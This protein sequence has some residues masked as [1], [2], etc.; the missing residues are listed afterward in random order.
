MKP[1]RMLIEVALPLDAINSGCEEDKNRKVGHIRNLHKWFA[2]MPL[3]AWRA[4]LLAS[5]I[6][7]PENDV[8]PGLAAKERQ[9]LFRLISAI[10][11]LD[12]IG[13]REVVDQAREAIQIATNGTIPTVVDPFCGGGSTIVEAQR[14]G[15]PAIGSDLNPIP[16]VITTVLCR[17]PQLFKDQQAINP[18]TRSNQTVNAKGL[19]AL[20]ADVRYYANLV[21][22]RAW[23]SLAPYYPSA[24]NGEQIFAWRWAWGIASPNPAARGALTPLVTD[25]T[26]SRTER[27][28]VSVIPRVIGRDINYT[29]TSTAEVPAPTA[30]GNSARCLFTNDPITF[31]YIRSQAKDG[32]LQP[33][34]FVM[35]AEHKRQKVFLPPSNVQIEAALDTG[36]LDVP[37]AALPEKALGFRVQGYGVKR[38]SDLFLP[39]QAR[40]AAKFSELVARVH[41]DILRDARRAGLSHM[42]RHL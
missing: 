23:Q 15:F 41:E 22:T 19:A 11:P 4:I 39:R 10:A 17:I 25:W 2:P 42:I 8:P 30:G 40:S 32:L 18:E 21:K 5:V 27:E 37:D 33:Q 13:K 12:S 34:M 26:L 7:D 3:P 38:F 1:K 36:G 9:R 29:V 14:L 31:D 35:L 24:E 6:Q 28:C 20:V 16:V